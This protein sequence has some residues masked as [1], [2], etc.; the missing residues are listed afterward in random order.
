[1]ARRYTQEKNVKVTDYQEI[2][3]IFD[4]W[5]L[6]SILVEIMTG[7]PLWLSLK[8]RVHSIDNRSIINTGLFG[9]AGRDNGKIL[10]KQL[11]ILG[12]G[13]NSLMK[14]LKQYD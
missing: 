11:E 3:Y 14:P 8:S 1:M 5:S 12:Q 6:G 10:K 7:F 13:L 9:V 2:S 4:M